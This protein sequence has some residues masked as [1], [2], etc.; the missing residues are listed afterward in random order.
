MCQ[1]CKDSQ[2]VHTWKSPPIITRSTPFQ[3][4]TVHAFPIDEYMAF[5][6]PCPYHLSDGALYE[7]LKAYLHILQRP[8]ERLRH[9]GSTTTLLL[10]TFATDE[11]TFVKF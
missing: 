2:V 4:F 11:A 1:R 8:L 7:D 9:Q 10:K 6:V 3:P 5:N